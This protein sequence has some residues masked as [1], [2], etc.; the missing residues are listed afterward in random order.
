MELENIQFFCC[1]QY[2]PIHRCE[3]CGC[4]AEVSDSGIYIFSCFTH[5]KDNSKQFEDLF[6][7]RTLKFGDE[8]A[9]AFMQSVRH[10]IALIRKQLGSTN[11]E[12]DFPFLSQIFM[13][14]RKQK[15]NI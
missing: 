14:I 6:E 9:F 5:S 7:I 1:N 15:Y 3:T 2:W 4:K 10:E 8:K 13:Y 11:P 12:Q